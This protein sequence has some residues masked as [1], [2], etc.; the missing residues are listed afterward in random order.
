MYSVY[1]I[2]AVSQFFPLKRV[3]SGNMRSLNFQYIIQHTPTYQKQLRKLMFNS[4][5]AGQGHIQCNEW[6]NVL[7]FMLSYS[8]DF[9]PEIIIQLGTIPPV[10]FDFLNS[11]HQDQTQRII[12][13]LEKVSKSDVL[14]SKMAWVA[15]SHLGRHL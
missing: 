10:Q 5:K 6:G 3:T 8:P 2:Y 11:S 15:G 4:L 12:F 14:W 13:S 1:A 9:S 7:M